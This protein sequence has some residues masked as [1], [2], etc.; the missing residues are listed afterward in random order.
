MNRSYSKIRHIQEVNQ[1]L[2]NRL[3]NEQTPKLNPKPSSTLPVKNTTT[4]GCSGTNTILAPISKLWGNPEQRYFELKMFFNATGG[5]ADFQKGFTD[6]KNKI[7]GELKSTDPEKT[8]IKF[9]TILFVQGSASNYLNGALQPTNSN[10]GKKIDD[11]SAYTKFK[12]PTTNQYKTNLKYAETRWDNIKNYLTTNGK[13]L[14][15]F[16]PSEITNVKPSAYITDTGGCTDEERDSSKYP[17]P[18]QYAVIRGVYSLRPK[19]NDIIITKMRSC[20]NNLK[21]V[22]GYFNNKE[23][24]VTVDD[25]TVNLNTKTHGC[26]NATF[27]VYCNDAFLATVNLNNGKYTNENPKTASMSIGANNS[28][29]NVCEVKYY[30]PTTPGGTVYSELTLTPKGIETL[31]E[32]GDGTKLNFSMKGRADAN[33]RNESGK[34][35]MHGEAP[36]VLVYNKLDNGSRIIYHKEPLTSQ[37]FKVETG[38]SVPLGTFEACSTA[39]K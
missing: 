37:G 30:P 25:I 32:Y 4:G 12:G 35:Y 8:E 13:S 36:M 31:I 15:F 23:S 17:N 20:I 33:P 7:M 27:D 39:A 5:D 14:G 1:R 29:N 11:F 6:L 16:I 24:A 2:E 34:T 9:N 21:V 10:D 3:L 19:K 22:I 26:A 18:G 38:I 28:K